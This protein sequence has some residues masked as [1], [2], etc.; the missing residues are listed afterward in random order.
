MQKSTSLKQKFDLGLKSLKNA[1]SL[2]EE[3]KELFVGFD[4]SNIIQLLA[5]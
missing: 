5:S 4:L 3:S 2:F 1:M